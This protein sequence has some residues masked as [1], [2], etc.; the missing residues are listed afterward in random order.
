MPNMAGIT[1]TQTKL[2]SLCPRWFLAPFTPPGKPT[3]SPLARCLKMQ[4]RLHARGHGNDRAR[5]CPRG[6]AGG[7]AALNTG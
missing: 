6:T 1:M 5:E 2:I 7:F 3:P 4:A